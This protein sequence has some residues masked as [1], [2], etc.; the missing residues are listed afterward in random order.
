MDGTDD[1]CSDSPHYG[2]SACIG[3]RQM[4]RILRARNVRKLEAIMEHG[5]VAALEFDADGCV[6]RQRTPVGEFMSGCGRLLGWNVV[7]SN[8]FSVVEKNGRFI[9]TGRGLGHGTG[10]CQYGAAGLARGGY[11]WR[12]ILHFYYPGARIARVVR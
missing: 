12:Q 2:W 1:L 4:D 10:L 6:A 5:R 8:L 11:P 7:K 3:P 9:F